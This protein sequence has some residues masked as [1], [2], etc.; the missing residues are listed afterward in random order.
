MTT[1]AVALERR[2]RRGQI[3]VALAA[4]AWSSAAI[5]AG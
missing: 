4:L 1:A 2:Q 3:D 5:R